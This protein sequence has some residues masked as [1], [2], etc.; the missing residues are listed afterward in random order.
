M[1]AIIKIFIGT[2]FV[3][4]LNSCSNF[5][6]EVQNRH[7]MLVCSPHEIAFNRGLI[8]EKVF[9]ELINIHI[10]TDYGKSLLKSFDN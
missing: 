4:F 9:T 7:K 8:S 2:F 6:R 3:F 1:S 10:N 5:I